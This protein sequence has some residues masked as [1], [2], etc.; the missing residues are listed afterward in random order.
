LQLAAGVSG[1]IAA[2]TV[3][4]CD[5]LFKNSFSLFFYP[6]A[7]GVNNHTIGYFNGTRRHKSISASN[8]YHADT[9]STSGLETRVVAKR[10]NLDSACCANLQNGHFRACFIDLT[11]NGYFYH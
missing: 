6:A 3:V 2:V 9:A 10:G 4:V 8:F 1:A 7:L 5:K 11:I